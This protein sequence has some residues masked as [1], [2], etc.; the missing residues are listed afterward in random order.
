MARIPAETK[1]GFLRALWLSAPDGAT[2]REV[3]EGFLLNGFQWVK[4][5]RIVINTSGAGHQTSFSP[6]STISELSQ[7]A[8]FQL[9]EEFLEVME[10]VVG[11]SPNLTDDAL[12]KEMRDNLPT[13]REEML[14]T[15]GVRIFY[16]A[17]TTI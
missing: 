3:L 13:V 10:F 5:G 1:R 6:G 16:G 9:A 7:E 12:E 17:G 14:D 15:M 8:V 2:L 4:S 11:Y